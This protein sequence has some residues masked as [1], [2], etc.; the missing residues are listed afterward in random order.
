MEQV[1]PAEVAQPA[2]SEE[3]ERQYKTLGI[4]VDNDLHAKLSFISQ[5]RDSTLS[6]EIVQAIRDRVEAAQADPELIEK[7]AEVRAQIEREARARQ[8]A[9]AGM[10]GATALAGTNSSPQEP[11]R[12]SQRGSRADGAVE[13]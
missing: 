11:T 13:R 12:R 2:L 5:L 10:F 6:G 9:I 1:P 7:A 3:L 4:R 8:E